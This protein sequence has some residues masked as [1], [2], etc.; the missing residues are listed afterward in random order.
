M[1]ENIVSKKNFLSQVKDIIKSNLRNILIFLSLSF[2]IFLSF[3]IYSYYSINKIQKNSIIF[4]KL[5][6]LENTNEIEE[7]INDL[8]KENNFYSILSKLELINSK[9]DKGNTQDSIQLYLELLSNENLNNIYK[10]AIASKASYELIEFNMSNLSSDFDK[11]IKKIASYIDEDL[12]AYKGINMEINYLIKILEA[13][14][15][16]FD[17]NDFNG[18]NEIYNHIMNSEFASSAIKERAKKIHEFLS[19]K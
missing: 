5:Q 10:S 11:E 15:N 7:I 4:F 2:I 1:N 14:K 3:Q 9:I 18:A 6:N 8:T 16:N 19:Y 12:I 13:Q 17:Y